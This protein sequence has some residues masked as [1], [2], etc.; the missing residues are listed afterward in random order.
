MHV[1]HHE[2]RTTLR[3]N[4]CVVDTGDVRVVHQRQRLALGLEAGNDLLRVHPGFDDLERHLPADRPPLFRQPHLAHPARADPIQQTIRSDL[5]GRYRAHA[6]SRGVAQVWLGIPLP[7]G[8]CSSGLVVREGHRD[9]TQPPTGPPIKPRLAGR[10]R[11]TVVRVR[12]RVRGRGTVSREEPT[13]SPTVGSLSRRC[14]TIHRHTEDL[15]LLLAIALTLTSAHA[16]A[17]TY[18]RQPGVDT[19][20]YVFRLTLLTT[21]SNEIEGNA[22]V[23][24]RIAANGVKDA[25]LDLTSATPDGKG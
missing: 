4:S 21:D 19:D 22:T 5:A 20:H 15:A 24:L 12:R 1:F 18:P 23:R 9:S 6:S 10:R 8:R 16:L 3:R 7:G 17:D 25:R 13:T 14:A 11:R 2:V